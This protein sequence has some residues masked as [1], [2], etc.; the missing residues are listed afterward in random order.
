MK[1]PIPKPDLTRL[2]KGGRDINGRE[3]GTLSVKEFGDWEVRQR[4]VR[5]LRR[6]SERFEERRELASRKGKSLS[7]NE[8]LEERNR[9]K[10]LGNLSGKRMGRYEGDPVWDDVV[11]VAQ[12]DGEGALAQIAY[13]EEYA[14]GMSHFGAYFVLRL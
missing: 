9:R 1:S 6:D 3:L 11:P 7:E 10:L 4:E 13:S 2:G 12:V 8:V 14:E 5:E